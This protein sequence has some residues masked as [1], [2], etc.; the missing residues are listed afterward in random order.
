MKIICSKENLLDGINI[1][2]K[3]VSTKTTLPILE[4]ILIEA[5]ERIKMT[6]NDLEIGIECYVDADIKRPGSIVLNSK[7]FGDIVRRLPDSEVLIEVKEND[8][9][10]IECENS[11]FEIKGISSEG[12]PS[13]PS[14][15]KEE[16]IR[17]SKK[18]LKDMIKQTIFAVSIDE[19]RPILT[20]SLFEYKSG[21]LTIVSIDGY[22]LAMRCFFSENTAEGIDR[23]LVIPGKTLNEIAKIIQPVDEDIYIYAAGNQILFDMGNCIMTSRLLEGE[24]LNYMGIIPSE[25][26]TKITVNTKDLLACFERASLVIT[27]EERRYPVKLDISDDLVIITANT[28]A[29]N[30]RE[31]IRAEMEGKKLD[32]SFNHRYFI[33][34]LRVIDNEMVDIF[35]TTNIGPCTIKP[36]QGNDFAYL[37]LPIRK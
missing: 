13:L 9:V 10:I 17:I 29:G 11:L 25:H 7:M 30:V 33:E 1:V 3:A 36:M 18:I 15:E 14:I 12:F 26:E 5:D 27:N 16:G 31:E 34:A 20:G 2:Q 24:Y 6:G 32:I 23:S 4:G 35:F 21:K 22:R 37:I 28:E 19:N 8:S